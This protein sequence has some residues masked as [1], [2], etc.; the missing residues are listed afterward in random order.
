MGRLWSL[1]NSIVDNLLNSRYSIADILGMIVTKKRAPEPIAR[2][3]LINGVG[4]CCHLESLPPPSPL[5]R[6]LISPSLAIPDQY[7]A[8]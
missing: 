5:N 7:I 8:K 2:S 1:S 3:Q 4:G 6:P